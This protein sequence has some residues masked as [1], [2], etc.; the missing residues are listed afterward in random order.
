MAGGNIH[1]GSFE[2]S[3]KSGSAF[4]GVIKDIRLEI[5]EIAEDIDQQLDSQEYVLLS[6]EQAAALT[7]P[8]EKYINY[9]VAQIGHDNCELEIE[10]EEKAGMDSIEG[11]W[12]LSSGWRLYCAKNL[13][14]ACKTSLLENEP[15]CIAFS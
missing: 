3:D 7:V 2:A 15:V 12:G 10:N 13:L 11:K 5:Y 14:G 8:L 4:E 6:T 9:L 1:C